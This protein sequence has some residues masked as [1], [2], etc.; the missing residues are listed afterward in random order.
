LSGQISEQGTRLL[1]QLSESRII[2]LDRQGPKNIDRQSHR[3]CP[4]VQ[5]NTPASIT[6][7]RIG[8]PKM[9]ND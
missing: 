4:N 8:R 2:A 5:V 6:T 9:V 7:I 3:R 1:W